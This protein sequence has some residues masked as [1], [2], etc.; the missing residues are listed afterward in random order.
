MF[1]YTTLGKLAVIFLCPLGG[2]KSTISIV[3]NP[4]FSIVLLSYQ[5]VLALGCTGK[6]CIL[7]FLACLPWGHL[8]GWRFTKLDFFFTTRWIFRL[9]Y[10]P[11]CWCI[12]LVPK[13]LST[14][15]QAGP[16]DLQT[17]ADRLVQMSICASLARKFPKVTIIGEEVSTCFISY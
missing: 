1:G 12:F 3:T 13:F 17:K 8:L 2:T 14:L 10:G 5:S 4:L 6:L 9:L 11:L 15:G 16:N 7:Q